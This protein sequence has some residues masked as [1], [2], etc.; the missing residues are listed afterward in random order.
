[1]YSQFD[2]VAPEQLFSNSHIAINCTFKDENDTPV[3]IT[4][5]EFHL[6]LGT[7]TGGTDVTS[8]VQILRPVQP[9]PGQQTGN[10]IVTFM[11]TNLAAGEYYALFTGMRGAEELAFGSPLTIRAVDQIQVCIDMLLGSLKGKYNMMVPNQYYTFDPRKRQWTDGECY[12][13]LEL[14]VM[15]I[16]NCPPLLSSPFTVSTC[17]VLNYMIM[18]A[19][20]YLL[21]MVEGLDVVN[22]FDITTPIKVNLYRGDKI[23]GYMAFIRES[24][25]KAIE[26]WKQNYAFNNEWVEQTLL[27]QRVPIRISRPV[28]DELYFHR[29]AW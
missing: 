12:Q 20:I 28:S 17:P 26:I 13:A 15:D 2:I 23:Q 7:S 3:T 6:Y 29:I 25:Q 14:A 5:P 24:Y 19:Q 1:V 4:S 9:D 10:Y 18:G 16:N 11:S 27:M 8:T 21:G 22:Y